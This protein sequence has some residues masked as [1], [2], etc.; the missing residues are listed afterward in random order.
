MNQGVSNVRFNNNNKN[1]NA[2][3]FKAF[4]FSIIC[5]YTTISEGY[6]NKVISIELKK[7]FL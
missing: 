6:E 7:I 3:K 1:L 4:F 5:L 2:A